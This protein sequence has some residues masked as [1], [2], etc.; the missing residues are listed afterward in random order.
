[1]Y[2]SILGYMPEGGR[3]PE[4]G[5][6]ESLL[7]RVRDW[8]A[9]VGDLI[10]ATPEKAITRSDIFGG[11][12]LPR[13]GVDRVTLLGDAAHPMTT[14][15]GQGACMAIED[16]VVISACLQANADPVAALRA[17]EVQRQARTAMIMKAQERFGSTAARE[18]AVRCWIRN[19]VIKRLFQRVVRPRYEATLAAGI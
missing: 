16:G 10:T 15:L 7:A 19:Q 6:K 18:T 17:Y 3:D 2:W 12:P 14:V 5:L 8:V 13:W 9:P 11:E 4:S 1:M